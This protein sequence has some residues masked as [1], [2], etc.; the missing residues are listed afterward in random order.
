MRMTRE[1]FA[2]IRALQIIRTYRITRVQQ[3]GVFMWPDIDLWD[4]R[5]SIRN[6]AGRFLAR[7]E[8]RGLIRTSSVQDGLHWLT[9]DGTKLLEDSE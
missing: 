7:L 8:Q 2:T 6:S 9:D 3:F 4:R 1:Q 5:P